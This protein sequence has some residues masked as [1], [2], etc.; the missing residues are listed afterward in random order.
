MWTVLEKVKSNYQSWLRRQHELNKKALILIEKYGFKT[1]L[2]EE[3]RKAPFIRIYVGKNSLD[4]HLKEIKS[5]FS[6]NVWLCQKERFNPKDHYLIFSNKEKK[7]SIINGHRANISGEY[8][9][10]DYNKSKK[11][12][13]IPTDILRSATAFFKTIKKRYEE[14]LQK[15]IPDF[16]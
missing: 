10:S 16:V 13:V 12:L 14:Q 1:A 3:E 11:I 5:Q 2:I 15:R 4:F 8:R 7:W 9:T 6:R